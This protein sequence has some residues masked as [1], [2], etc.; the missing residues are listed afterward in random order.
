MI[1]LSRINVL[2]IVAFKTNNKKTYLNN[3]ETWC[4]QGKVVYNS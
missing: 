2:K 4:E 1:I 3:S